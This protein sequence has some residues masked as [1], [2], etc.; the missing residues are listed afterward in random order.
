[1]L[2]LCRKLEHALPVILNEKLGEDHFA[3]T[4][5]KADMTPDEITVTVL[6]NHQTS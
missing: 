2:K 1:M 5:S 3:G 6:L 4:T